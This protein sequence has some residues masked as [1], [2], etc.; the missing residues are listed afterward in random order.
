M[1]SLLFSEPIVFV[2]YALALLIA[3]SIHEYAHA[4]VAVMLGDPTPEVQGRL[5]LDPRAHLDLYG[6]LL[7]LLVGFGWGKP[8]RFDPYNLE[9][10]RRDAALISIAGP[11]SNAILAI[12]SAIALRLLLFVPVTFLSDIGQLFFS[13]LIVLNVILGVFN[14]LPIAPLDGFKIVGG[15]LNE[16]QAREWYQ[17]ER[18]GIFFLLLL[19][20]P[21]G[22]QSMLDTILRPILDVIYTI[23]IP[24]H[25]SGII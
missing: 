17:L 5:T 23:L 7:L 1:I 15:L 19:L 18:Y 20:V 4:R 6:A 25:T 11:V 24:L 2:F 10:P 14:L 3:I 16:E 12:I 13:S 9:N 22:Q 8:V 21:F